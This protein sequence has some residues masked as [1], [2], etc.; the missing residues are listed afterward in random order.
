MAQDSTFVIPEFTNP[1]GEIVFRL[2]GWLDGKRIRKNF[3]TRAEAV[4]ERQALEISLVQA[5]SSVRTAITRLTDSQ[6]HDAEVAFSRLGNAPKSLAFY[7]EYAL[8]NYRAPEREITVETAATTYLATKQTAYGRGLVSG[9]QLKDIRIRLVTLK[10]AFP[11]K[12]LSQLTREALAAHCQQGNPKPKTFNNRRGVL[13]TF[14][15]FAFYQD[16]VAANP[17]DKVPHLRIAYRRGSAKTLTAEQ[18]EKLMRHIETFEG[19]VF[20][21]YF[22]LCLFAGIRPSILVGEISK[23]QPDSINLDTGVIH[24]EHEVSKVRMKRNVTILPNLDAWLR[25]YALLAAGYLDRD[26][27]R[28]VSPGY[29]VRRAD[30]FRV[31]AAFPRVIEASLPLGVGSV[32]YDL[33]L[34]ACAVFAVAPADLQTVLSSTFEPAI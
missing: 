21:T 31:N 33:S 6:L 3:P 16:W 17:L 32:S 29:A 27:S 12:V 18:A 26:A 1:S 14:F 34:A 28:Y 25:A 15:K 7:G 24:I 9:C 22:S 11:G 23:L 2:F 5:Q 8:A 13:F 30:T 4:A 10:K 19:G 20:V